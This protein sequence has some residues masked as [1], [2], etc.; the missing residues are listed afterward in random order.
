MTIAAFCENSQLDYYLPMK[1][2]CVN[3]WSQGPL[4][5]NQFVEKLWNTHS[6]KFHYISVVSEEAHKKYIVALKRW[7]AVDLKQTMKPIPDTI[8]VRV[9]TPTFKEYMNMTDVDKR[10]INNLPAFVN[11][12]PRLE[13]VYGKTWDQLATQDA[14]RHLLELGLWYDAT[15]LP[16]LK[17]KIVKAIASDYDIPSV[18]NQLFK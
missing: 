7:I 17:Q 4:R 15:D 1:Y 10:Y 18:L 5:V 11:L 6:D 9:R 13:H 8:L 16:T 2:T 14:S 3:A 12:V